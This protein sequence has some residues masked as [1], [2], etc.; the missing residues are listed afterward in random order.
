M[1]FATGFNALHWCF[2]DMFGKVQTR[3]EMVA[4]TKQ[5]SSA[6]LVTR[7]AH[8]DLDFAHKT[9]TN[10]IALV[11]AIQANYG[12]V[13]THFKGYLFGFSAVTHDVYPSLNLKIVYV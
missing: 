13:P 2:L 8:I 11:G 1:P 6:C 5:H 4:V 7:A 10:R 12:Y 3:A 9:I